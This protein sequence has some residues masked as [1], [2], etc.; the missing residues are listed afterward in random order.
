MCTNFVLSGLSYFEKHDDDDD[1][2]M[3]LRGYV[4]H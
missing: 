4:S 3:G 2:D 1:D